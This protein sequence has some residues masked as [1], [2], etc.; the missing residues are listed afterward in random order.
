MKM[1]IG[2]VV[3]LIIIS[4]M[5]VG[6]D[7]VTAS[8]W[9]KRGY[10]LYKVNRNYIE[11]IKCIDKAIELIPTC[12]SGACD[13]ASCDKALCSEAWYRRGLCL[14]DPKYQVPEDL[15]HG[16]AIACYN[17]AI[18]INSTYV[19][20]LS[21]RGWS[22]AELRMYKESLESLDRALEISPCFDDAWNNKGVTLYYMGKLKEALECFYKAAECN[23][24]WSDPWDNIC[25]VLEELDIEGSKE[26]REAACAKS[27]LLEI[28]PY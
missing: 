4:S 2:I 10:D 14:A 11:A 9:L 28:R 27:T 3:A 19:E 1:I 26:A 24:R 8:E 22:L 7:D 13:N 6:K 25:T 15:N 21:A 12:S 5:A 18:S 23:P 16:E 17:K 20:A